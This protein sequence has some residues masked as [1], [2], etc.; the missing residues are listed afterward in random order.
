MKKI[1]S[2]L[3]L[4][5]VLNRECNPIDLIIWKE[6]V[7][8]II[9]DRYAIQKIFTK[10]ITKWPNGQTIQVFIKPLQSIEHKDFVTNVLGISPFYYQQVLETQLNNNKLT[11]IIEI[12]TDKQMIMK[13]E[14]TPGA[15]GYVNY[16]VITG[17][18][19]VIVVDGN[20]IP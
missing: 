10:Q 12:P 2:I 8:S 14:S 7:D 20:K 16:E 15:I 9:L 18:K 19:T 1:I 4:W 5:I 11:S 13:V 17:S 6:T 3:L